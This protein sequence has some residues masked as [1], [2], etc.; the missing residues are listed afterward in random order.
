MRVSTWFS[1]AA[2]PG[3]ALEIRGLTVL[4]RWL[5]LLRGVRPLVGLIRTPL[6]TP[7]VTPQRP[8][9]LR[10]ADPLPQAL[11][12]WGVVALPQVQPQLGDSPPWAAASHG[13]VE[14]AACYRWPLRR[15]AE[16]GSR[17]RCRAAHPVSDRQ[18][19]VTHR[20]KGL[21]FHEQTQPR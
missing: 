12:V 16:L 3:N 8:L 4:A 13:Q 10:E 1:V 11:L 14:G 20:P 15:R 6:E 7:R 21:Y 17:D 19:H 9:L 2:T 5:L 18:L